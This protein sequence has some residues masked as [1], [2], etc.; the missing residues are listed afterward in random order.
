MRLRGC[1]TVAEYTLHGSANGNAT[2]A[3]LTLT[4]LP[5]P[6]PNAG[7]D[8]AAPKPHILERAIIR[9][10]KITDRLTDLH[11]FAR[12]PVEPPQQTQGLAPSQ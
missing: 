9:L 1:P 6:M 3:G 7:F 5:A 4:A 10:V 11:L 12:A 2:R 8:L